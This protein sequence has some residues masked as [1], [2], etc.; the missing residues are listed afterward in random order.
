[1]KDGTTLLHICAQ[2]NDEEVAKILIKCGIIFSYDRK[3]ES[4]AE[5]ASR[6]DSYKVLKLIMDCG[7]AKHVNEQIPMENNSS[8][9]LRLI[10]RS[11]LSS[12]KRIHGVIPEY[13]GREMIEYYSN[14]CR[15]GFLIPSFEALSVAIELFKEFIPEHLEQ[16]LSLSIPLNIRIME[17]PQILKLFFKNGASV[18]DTYV[19]CDD[20]YVRN[21][22]FWFAFSECVSV[23]NK[24]KLSNKRKEFWM[25]TCYA[26]YKELS[27]DEYFLED[28]KCDFTISPSHDFIDQWIT[29]FSGAISE[30]NVIATELLIALFASLVSSCTDDFTY[31][32]LLAKL[33]T[34]SCVISDG[35]TAKADIAFLNPNTPETRKTQIVEII[36]LLYK[37]GFREC[38]YCYLNIGVSTFTQHTNE[39]IHRVTLYEL[40]HYRIEVENRAILLKNYDN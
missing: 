21:C 7:S 10:L 24:G 3:N 4:A 20:L 32:R 11:K 27:R 29:A 23:S 15:N 40:L 2:F 18:L 8:E 5:I 25:I 37:A 28:V 31:I 1:M 12:I 22:L 13:K 9:C 17:Y 36:H 30:F 16:I 6:N 26:V 33:L 19:P 14:L 38:N 34:D 35:F 39:F